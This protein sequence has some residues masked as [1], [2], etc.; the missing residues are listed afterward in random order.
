MIG[1]LETL[2]LVGG[3][4]GK[5]GALGLGLRTPSK[6]TSRV[7]DRRVGSFVNEKEIEGCLE[8]VG[9]GILRGLLSGDECY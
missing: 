1:S 8:G 5:G 9:G 7:E 3:A 2:S 6:K 4:E